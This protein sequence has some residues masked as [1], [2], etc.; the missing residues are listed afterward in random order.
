MK[1]NEQHKE[2]VGTMQGHVLTK[3]GNGSEDDC[4]S[5]SQAYANGHMWSPK[6]LQEV[7]GL[8]VPSEK[9]GIRA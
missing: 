9:I 8:F 7:R 3:E 6:L 4:W 2:N 1:N 5:L